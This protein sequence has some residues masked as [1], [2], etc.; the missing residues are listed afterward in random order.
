MF[1]KLKKHGIAAHNGCGVLAKLKVR[2]LSI[3]LINKIMEEKYYTPNVNEFHIGFGYELLSSYPDILYTIDNPSNEP[4]WVKCIV[5][6]LHTSPKNVLIYIDDHLSMNTPDVRVKYLDKDDIESL[7]FVQTLEDKENY[8]FEGIKEKG[9]FLNHR[10][11]VIRIVDTR[12]VYHQQL[13]WGRIK[14]KFELQ[15]LLQQLYIK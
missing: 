12:F 3:P 11:K 14:N 2:F 9:L 10:G 15:K 8:F 5:K 6:N 4:I 13:F 7:G 1:I